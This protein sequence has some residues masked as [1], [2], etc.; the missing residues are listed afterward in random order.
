MHR[1][2][3]DSESWLEPRCGAEESRRGQRVAARPG[4]VPSVDLDLAGLGQHVDDVR[5]EVGVVHARLPELARVPVI[6]PV[7][8]P[9]APAVGP[10]AV[11]VHLRVRAARVTARRGPGSRGHGRA[12]GRGRGRERGRGAP[13]RA[14]GGFSAP[15]ALHTPRRPGTP[16]PDTV[17]ED[18]VPEGQGC[19]LPVLL[20]AT[21]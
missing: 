7:V 19:S 18:T 17:P 2:G 6:L 10:E 8:V 20:P 5:L 13:T 9:V 14:G 4:S 12:L 21:F 16:N 3:A 15:D 1:P 11:H